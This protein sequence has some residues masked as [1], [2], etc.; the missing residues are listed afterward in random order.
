MT[1]RGAVDGASLCAYV[2]QIR[3]HP[4][5]RL[6]RH[7]QPQLATPEQHI[8]RRPRPFLRDQIVDLARGQPAAE[9]LAQIAH[10]LRIAQHRRHPGAIGA[11]QPPQQR[12][13]Q[14][15]PR[16]H[17]R[18]HERLEIPAGQ[19][20]T[21]QHRPRRPRP[22]YIRQHRAQLRQRMF[23]ELAIGR[24][25]TAENAQHRRP[26][27]R[28]VEVEHIVARHRRGIAGMVVVQ[29][30][31]PG[32]APHD[33]A[34]AQ[35]AREI[36]VGRVEQ[37][38]SLARIDCGFRRRPLP[39][40]VGR[41]D[42]R[43]VAFIGNGED[44]PPVRVLQH[45]GMIAGIQARHDDM[46]ALHQPHGVLGMPARDAGQHVVHPRPRRVHQHPCRHHALAR[47]IGDRRDPALA[48]APCPHQPR[49]RRDRRPA[50][51]RV[52]RVQ[53]DQPAVLDPTIRIDERLAR[54]IAQ[55][56]AIRRRCQPHRLGR[57]QPRTIH[58]ARG[59][60]VC[61][62]T[63]RSGQMMCGAMP[64][65]RSRSISASRTNRNSPYSR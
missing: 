51:R 61:G 26:P 38:G 42:Q 62:S 7:M 29:R 37:I 18:R 14:P 31:D 41:P 35:P 15:W 2:P 20:A 19:V 27:R 9:I 34:L 16:P 45:E 23:G 11:R 52:A 43:E 64:H 59:E 44:D 30:P 39:R 8:L 1:D 17:Q 55:P 6:V 22:R 46:A 25:L 54:R 10:R 3:R 21:R 60:C 13:R 47:G 5:R 50:I 49:P 53:H 65:S 57:R 4:R 40:L 28:R 33:I 58:A 32:I 56:R 12:R 36:A 63:K 24:D 48:L